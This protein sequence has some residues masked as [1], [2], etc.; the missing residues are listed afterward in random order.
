MLF[1]PPYSGHLGLRAHEFSGSLLYNT[2]MD[3]AEPSIPHSTAV[4]ATTRPCPLIKRLLAIV[5][6]GLLLVGLWMIAAVAVVVPTNAGVAADTLWFQVYLAAVAWLYFAISWRRGCTLGMKAWHIRILAEQQPMGWFA[7]LVR[8]VVAI[9]SW[10]SV[11]LGFVWA[12][13]NANKSTWHDLASKS[14]L[15]IVT[16][17]AQATAQAT[18]QSAA[19]ATADSAPRQ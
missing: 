2:P 17:P 12:L 7:T 11:G 10:G 4:G 15:V 18:A 5:Y 8:F 9:A 1:S 19:E 6:D 14:R 13:F 16:K 3:T